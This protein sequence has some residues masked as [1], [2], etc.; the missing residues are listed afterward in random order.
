MLLTPTC[1]MRSDAKTRELRDSC[2]LPPRPPG[3]SPRATSGDGSL[4]YD[5]HLLGLWAATV[6]QA[7]C[8]HSVRHGLAR[9]SGVRLLSRPASVLESFETRYDWCRLAAWQ[10]GENACTSGSENVSTSSVS[11][12]HVCMPPICSKMPLS[13]LETGSRLPGR[14]K[15][16]DACTK[17]G[18]TQK[19]KVAAHACQNISK[20][21]LQ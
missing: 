10:A 4:E 13:R 17:Q 15:F 16:Q 12:R 9:G 21:L 18:K 19:P 8:S 1:K 20:A 6:V 7:E 5:R 14:P 11:S 2:C 3:G